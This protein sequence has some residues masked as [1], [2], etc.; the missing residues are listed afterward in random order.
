MY[1]IKTPGGGRDLRIEHG[2]SQLEGDFAR[3]RRDVLESRLPLQDEDRIKFLAFVAAMRSRTRRHRDHLRGEWGNV[4][5]KMEEMRRAVMRMTPQRRTA[6]SRIAA[7]SGPSL[8]LDDVTR[9]AQQPLQHMLPSMVEGHLTTLLQMNI[10]VLCTDDALGFITSDDPCLVY[11]PET[12]TRPFPHNVTGLAYKTAELTMPLSP[13]QTLLVSW[14]DCSGYVE[15]PA[16]LTAEANRQKRF[17][18]EE[19]FVVRRE[20]VRAE[21]FVPDAP[22]PGAT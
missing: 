20:E 1:T 22:P 21:W 17:Q 5:A 11:D 15:I 13:S 9:L 8:D 4:K 3:I 18:C 16:E 19:E 12:R 10:A 7:G 2:L 6:M 14:K